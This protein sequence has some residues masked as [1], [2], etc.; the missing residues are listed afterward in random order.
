MDVEKA[1]DSLD[2]NFLISTLENYGFSENF[3][4]WVKILFRDQE[5]CVLNGSTTTKYFLLRRGTF[6]KQYQPPFLL[7]G[8]LSVPHFEKGGI[9]KYMNAWAALKNFCHRYLPGGTY[10]ISCQKKTL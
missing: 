5:L 3:N 7:G 4:S 9:R 10:H 1:F 8:Q 6:H 2:H